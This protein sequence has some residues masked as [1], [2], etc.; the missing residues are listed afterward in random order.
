MK[1][2]WILPLAAVLS[3]GARAQEVPVEPTPPVVEEESPEIPLPIP[4]GGQDDATK[5]IMELFQ[6]VNESL[7]RID[8]MLFDMGAG[9]RPLE[10]PEDSGLGALLD[11]AR[12][13]SQG[14]VEGID[15]IL[16]LA[17]EMASEQ[18][19]SSSSSSQ[20]GQPQGQQS[21]G[22]NSEK[23]EQGQNQEQPGQEQEGQKDP[24]GADQPQGEEPDGKQP[25]SPEESKGVG[26]N[27]TDGQD[28]THPTGAGSRA[29]ITERWGELP[30]RVRE[31]FRNQGGEEAPLYYRDWIDS[32]YRHLSRNDG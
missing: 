2:S 6:K 26:A 13:S 3:L 29:D 20:S 28:N 19:Q 24:E 14:V 10:A 5:E 23:K 21:G 1:R 27:T 7:E 9:E 22:Q 32:Y 16:Q 25:D 8:D 12:E 18:Q 17:D 15:R 4:R 30:E 31:T 11:L